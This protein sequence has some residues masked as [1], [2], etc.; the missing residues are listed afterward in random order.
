MIK[1]TYC[2]RRLPHL[3]RAQFQDYW[4]HTHGPLVQRHAKLLNVRRYAQ[5]HTTDEEMN[6]VLRKLN[7]SPEPFDGV[8]ELWFDSVEALNAPASTP[9]GRAALKS[10]REDMKKF[11]D[12]ARSPRWLGAETVLVGG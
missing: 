7:A 11:A 4:L 2:L 12:E 10:L 6:E 1:V 9:E 5:V 8:A 3:S